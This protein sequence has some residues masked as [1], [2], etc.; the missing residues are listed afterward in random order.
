MDLGYPSKTVVYY[1]LIREITYLG[2]GDGFPMVSVPMHV[3]RI[4]QDLL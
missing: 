3:M 2:C 1:L 4:G